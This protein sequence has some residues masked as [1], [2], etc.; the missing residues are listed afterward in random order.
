M[1]KKSVNNK[2]LDAFNLTHA[3][4]NHSSHFFSLDL[5]EVM[6]CV[7][8]FLQ[9]SFSAK[10]MKKLREMCINFTLRSYLDVMYDV[11]FIFQDENEDLTNKRHH[12]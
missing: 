4:L 1:Q 11:V 7:F 2:H 9:Y 10:Q 8:L 3:F 6:F 5:Y 12:T